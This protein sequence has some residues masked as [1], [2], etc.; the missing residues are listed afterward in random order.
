MT[1]SAHCRAMSWDLAGKDPALPDPGELPRHW[2]CVPCPLSVAGNTG[3]HTKLGIELFHSFYRY[4]TVLLLPLLLLRFGFFDVLSGR[5]KKGI[6]QS[7]KYRC[8][9]LHVLYKRQV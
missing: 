8:F 2:F 1:G 9:N 4:L 5:E 7:Q 3:P 6:V